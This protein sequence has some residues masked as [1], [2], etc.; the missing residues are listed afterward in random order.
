MSRSFDPQYYLSKID[1]KESLTEE[2]CLNM[3]YY[4]DIE[5]E[6]GENRRWSRWVRTICKLNDRY[7]AVEWDQGLTE[8]QDDSCFDQPYEVQ[9]HEYDKVIRVKEWIPIF[10]KEEAE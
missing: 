4:F 10:P 6:Y 3:A 2:E 5:N 7:F 9:L 8:L 1:A